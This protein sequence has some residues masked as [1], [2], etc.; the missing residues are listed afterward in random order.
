[1]CERSYGYGG[2]FR[3]KHEKR[4]KEY[5][6][7]RGVESGLKFEE[8]E[9][10]KM[11]WYGRY[12]VVQTTVREGY[13]VEERLIAVLVTQLAAVAVEKAKPCACST[14]LVLGVVIVI[15]RY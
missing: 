4:V 2:R 7:Q 6:G 14:S 15:A 8:K 1:M 12:K 11:V 3:R 13:V 9:I 10:I 5:R